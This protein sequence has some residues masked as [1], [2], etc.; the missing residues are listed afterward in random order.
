VLFRNS[1]FG[2]KNTSYNPNVVI[3]RKVKN[4]FGT[5]KGKGK[6]RENKPKRKEEEGG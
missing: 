2:L 3:D 6:A 1:K 5:S 4:S